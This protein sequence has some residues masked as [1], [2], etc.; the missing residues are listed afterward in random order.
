LWAY[1]ALFNTRFRYELFMKMS[2]VCDVLY[3]VLS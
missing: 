3:L 1:D 2:P